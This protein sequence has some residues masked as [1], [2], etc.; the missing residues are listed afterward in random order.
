VAARYPKATMAE[1]NVELG[2]TLREAIDAGKTT[3]VDIK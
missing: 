3:L 1:I 2:A